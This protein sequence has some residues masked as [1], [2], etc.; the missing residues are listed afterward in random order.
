MEM[1]NKKM[2]DMMENMEMNMKNMKMKMKDMQM[3]MKG[4]EC[5]CGSGKQ[6]TDCCMC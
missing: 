4:M 5:P 2:G 6:A 3:K 1:K